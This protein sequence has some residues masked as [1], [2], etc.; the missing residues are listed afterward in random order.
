LGD[1]PARGGPIVVKNGKYGPYV[2]H[3]GVNATL[4]SDITPET[5]TLAQA[6]ELIDARAGKS[7]GGKS[8]GRAQPRR[9]AG[10]KQNTG[11]ATA[12]KKKEVA[13]KPAAKPAAK[14]KAKTAPKA[15]TKAAA[16]PAKKKAVR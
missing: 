3:N 1:H 8:T 2:S 9:A 5:V 12:P 6:V 13:A 14:A 4:P 15:A 16:K 11:S 10:R 7:G